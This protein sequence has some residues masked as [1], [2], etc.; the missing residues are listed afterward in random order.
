MEAARLVHQPEAPHELVQE[1]RPLVD[2]VGE[3]RRPA[4]RHARN[5]R[6]EGLMC[7][8]VSGSL[9]SVTQGFFNSDAGLFLHAKEPFAGV[10]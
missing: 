6:R 10:P 1:A 3:V 4:R 5:E 7:A 2:Q 8:C 9:L